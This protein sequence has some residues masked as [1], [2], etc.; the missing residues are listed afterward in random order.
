MLNAEIDSMEERI[1]G[2]DFKTVTLGMQ[3]EEFLSLIVLATTTQIIVYDVVHSDTI[4]LESGVKEILESERIIKVYLIV[5]FPQ[6]FFI[7]LWSFM[8][9]K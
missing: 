8:I 6:R 4:L 9:Q 7:F 3:G 1:V 5:L 2:V